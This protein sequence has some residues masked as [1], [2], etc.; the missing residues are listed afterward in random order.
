MA[1]NETPTE[2]KT[3]K[4]SITQKPM[5]D[6]AIDKALAQL[7]D[8]D[9]DTDKYSKQVDQV[10]K[11]YKLKEIDSRTRVS[12]DTLAVVA[13]NLIGILLIINHERVNVITTKALGFVLK[14]PR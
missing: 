7:G 3:V 9:I 12:A 8:G 6:V 2:R 1:Y 4:V 14:S 10:A 11:L 5:L 13:G